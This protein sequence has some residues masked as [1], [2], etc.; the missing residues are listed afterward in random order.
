MSFVGKTGC[1]FKTFR[2]GF[3]F[4]VYTL[5]TLL[6]ISVH[7]HDAFRYLCSSIIFHALLHLLF[8]SALMSTLID[9][10]DLSRVK[11]VRHGNKYEPVAALATENILGSKM[12]K[13]GLFVHAR[14][15]F[16]ASSP[17]RI[18]KLDGEDDET[19]VEIKCPFTN[20][21]HSI[22]PLSVTYLQEINGEL[23]LKKTHN[24]YYQVQGQMACTGYKKCLFVVHTLANGGD[25]KIM[26]IERDNQFI[27][28][29]Q[30]KLEEFNENFYKDALL[31]KYLFK[32]Y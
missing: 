31:T 4:I 6:K 7:M 24:Y 8:Q 10:P 28:N 27:E 15:P 13:C 5:S 1:R 21:E 18:V 22:S 2:T 32:N 17:D 12:N 29:M 3:M 25:T 20:S 30:T 16:L 23:F 19:V 11:A 9:P 26:K 14:L